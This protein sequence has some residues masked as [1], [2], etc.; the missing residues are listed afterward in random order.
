MRVARRSDR[1]APEAAEEQHRETC[2]AQ[3]DTGRLGHGLHHAEG[4][5]VL[6]KTKIK[7]LLGY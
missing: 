4:G 2:P 6:K 5:D 1:S 3:R 7:H